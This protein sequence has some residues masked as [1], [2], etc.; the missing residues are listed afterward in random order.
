MMSQGGSHDT[1]EAHRHRRE[2]HLSSALSQLREA[3][4]MLPVNWRQLLFAT[5]L[6]RLID[7]T[8]VE[9]LAAD[10][11][12][13][14][15]H[16]TS[17]IM[18][19]LPQPRESPVNHYVVVDG[20]HRLAALQKVEKQSC[21][22]RVEKIYVN[23]LHLDRIPGLRLEEYSSL[24]LDLSTTLNDKCGLVRKTAFPHLLHSVI[25]EFH[26]N[27]EL[28][29][30]PKSEWMS[31]KTIK[32]VRCILQATR[33]LGGMQRAQ[34][35]RY[36]RAASMLALDKPSYEI[37]LNSVTDPSVATAWDVQTIQAEIF[38]KADAE[39]RHF[40]FQCLHSHLK[41]RKKQ[42]RGSSLKRL[43][44]IIQT[45]VTL[46]SSISVHQKEAKECV[47]KGKMVELEGVTVMDFILQKVAL[48]SLHDAVELFDVEGACSSVVSMV[49]ASLAS[50]SIRI[51][52][53]ET[54]STPASSG[55]ASVEF[56]PP[57]T[58]KPPTPAI[59]PPNIVTK[60]LRNADRAPQEVARAFAHEKS[61][62]SA[63]VLQ[64]GSAAVAPQKASKSAHARQHGSPTRAH[65]DI[66]DPVH[67]PRDV[68]PAPGQ[69]AIS[70]A[71][72]LANSSAGPL[73]SPKT[74][75]SHTSSRQR[76][77]SEEE[78][79]TSPKRQKVRGTPV[80][81]ASEPI[82]SKDSGNENCSI[83]KVVGAKPQ[84]REPM[85]A[86]NTKNTKTLERTR[87]T[88]D[89]RGTNR[90]TP[91]LATCSARLLPA[92]IPDES[93]IKYNIKDRELDRIR[94][95]LLHGSYARRLDVARVEVLHQGYTIL[96]LPDGAG[97]IQAVDNLLRFA[98]DSFGGESQG[99]ANETD[100][101]VPIHTEL[102][103]GTE[104]SSSKM[105]RSGRLQTTPKWFSEYLAV[106][107]PAIY[108]LKVLLDVAL[109]LIFEAMSLTSSSE[110]RDALSSH[111][112][113][114]E[115][116]QG[117]LTGSLTETEIPHMAFAPDTVKL[118]FVPCQTPSFF[119]EVSGIESFPF[120]VYRYSHVYTSFPPGLGNIGKKIS[121]VAPRDTIKVPKFSVL[122]GRGD[123]LHSRTGHF[124]FQL[125]EGNQYKHRVRLHIYL[126]RL[127]ATLLDL[128]H[129]PE[130][131]KS[132]SR[133][134]ALK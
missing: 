17:N 105:P 74:P 76:P 95:T 93:P 54:P 81:L 85:R 118:P 119:C 60:E 37:F 117:V 22:R 94:Q 130:W 71:T 100:G 8:H 27:M 72:L 62:N 41:H 44:D 131:D 65:T 59:A 77:N 101:W 89:G 133:D 129:V 114:V 90:Q 75:M 70:P 25:G 40:M 84:T 50:K 7:Q 13:D 58:P 103:A 92:C 104:L 29:S 20:S 73:S 79:K 49:Q 38:F 9:E 80:R 1:Q 97:L 12:K 91:S 52:V 108:R 57:G 15:F 26:S 4:C 39:D 109:S 115:G 42:L 83:E 125:I 106:K 6:A 66:S 127:D 11:T 110:S 87:L 121:E 43:I 16:S 10:I 36:A 30:I 56:S 18:T 32:K 134:R 34:C 120:H 53:P 64:G 88:D 51:Q 112:I 19:V 96:P 47:L 23:V 14:G 124:E 78:R 82:T 116:C 69:R 33:R 132:E 67:A 128:L 63:P 123:L 24:L 45:F 35:H 28:S 31:K 98:A 107:K 122:I 21:I 2:E 68:S 126:P 46:I 111:R 55:H 48:I 61:K 3:K 102:N 5:N 86:K 99:S 113:P